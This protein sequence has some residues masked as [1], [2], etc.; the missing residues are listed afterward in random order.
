MREYRA[1][2]ASGPSRITIVAREILALVA[3][4]SSDVEYLAQF[5]F[6]RDLRNDW[7][8]EQRTNEEV[9]IQ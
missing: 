2:G 7:L 6:L 5:L 1:G 4:G 8:V 9:K 3:I